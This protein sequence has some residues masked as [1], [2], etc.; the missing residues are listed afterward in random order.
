[1]AAVR[2]AAPVL[3][4]GDPPHPQ[5]VSIQKV[6]FPKPEQA[7]A[8][9]SE[10]ASFFIAKAL[11]EERNTR[12]T[13]KCGVAT[14]TDGQLVRIKKGRWEPPN[15]RFPDRT[16]T[17]LELDLEDPITRAAVISYLKNLPGVGDVMAEAI[18]HSFGDTGEGFDGRQLLALIDRDPEILLEVRSPSGRPLLGEAVELVDR[19]VELRGERK[20]R[21]YFSSLDL[22]ASTVQR[23]MSHL[24]GDRAA[25]RVKENPYLL[26]EVPGIGFATAD[27][28]G[29]KEGISPNDPRRVGYGIDEALRDAESEGHACLAPDQLVEW[30]Q[31]KLAVN[32]RAPDAAV[33]E[34]LVEQL[35]Q[36]GRLVREEI[37]PGESRLYHPE[38]Y[39]VETRTLGHLERLITKQAETLPFNFGRS[40][41]NA[42][43]TSEQ[44][45]AVENALIEPISI[46]TGG[47]GTGKTATLLGVLDAMDEAGQSYLLMAPTGKAAKRMSETTGRQA[48]TIHKA[49]GRDGL[50]APLSINEKPWERIEADLVVIDEASMLD[51]RLC[52]RVLS[53][54]SPKT[55]VLFCGDP[56]QLP[57]VGCGACLLDMLESGRVPTTELTRVFRQAQGSLLVVNA[58]RV[59]NGQEPFWTKQEAEAALGRELLDD[60]EFIEVDLDP[61]KGSVRKEVINQMK[62]AATQLAIDERDVLVTAPF[63]GGRGGVQ[64][65]NATLQEWHNPHG[66]EIR[67]G[68]NGIRVGDRVMNVKNRYAQKNMKGRD[69]DVMN[70][71]IGEITG[72]DTAR[73]TATV[74]FSDGQSAQSFTR[75]E[76]D[77]LVPAYCA[78]VHKLQGSEA[79]A[80]IA[81]LDPEPNETG[82]L[83]RNLIYTAWT[84]ARSKCVVIGSKEAI[85]AALARDAGSARQTTLDIRVGRIV[86]RLRSRIEVLRDIENRWKSYAAREGITPKTRR[87][88]AGGVSQSEAAAVSASR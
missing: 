76:L 61:E 55:R 77:A 43:L 3:A 31:Q 51:M 50:R 15:P 87:P 78:T 13:V 49:L 42:H 24:G 74:E 82:R 30:A 56:H 5:T 45:H 36:D 21:L 69:E 44:R 9:D 64:S 68:Q 2:G 83:S 37:G 7:Q 73:K 58:H 4:Q 59:K 86:P 54:L 20:A 52:E 23:I 63:N 38:L 65:L 28:V 40:G 12:L 85:V 88:R 81:P 34:Q 27:R 22:G 57:P 53:S 10:K 46:L 29:S 6:V 16:Y 32:G 35:I 26:C 17:I 71:D 66:D 8:A 60:W 70:G 48:S 39:L 72:W 41:K 80:I 62:K 25:E 75:E 47:P 1:M 18:C 67:G 11:D 33:I 84:R 79:P 19:W 14:L